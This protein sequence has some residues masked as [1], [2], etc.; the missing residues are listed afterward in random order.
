VLIEHG[1]DQR[2]IP[3]SPTTLIA[4]LR[5]V[6]YG[7][8]QEQLAGNAHEISQLGRELY[9]RIRVM[10]GH[11]DS[12]RRALDGATRSYNDAVGSFETRVLVT[13]RKFKELGAGSQEDVPD[14]EVVD[15]S[16]RQLQAPEMR[17]EP[18]SN[19]A[20]IS[21]VPRKKVG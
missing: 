1:A 14:L 21:G 16:A 18:D 20:T 19:T 12:L 3:A 4:L 8:R 5:A 15:R 7:W 13:A 17:T 9:D 6:A 2:V 11:F 10:A